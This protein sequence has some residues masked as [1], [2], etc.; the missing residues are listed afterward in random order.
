MGH[1]LYMSDC[2]KISNHICDIIRSLLLFMLSYE[3]KCIAEV[4]MKCSIVALIQ[5]YCLFD[6]FFK[7]LYSGILNHKGIVEL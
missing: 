2:H 3:S 7:G 6:L 4:I 5:M 1:I